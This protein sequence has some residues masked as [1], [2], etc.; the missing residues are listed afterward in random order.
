M[1]AQHGRSLIQVL[2][3]EAPFFGPFRSVFPVVGG[4]RPQKPNNAPSI[5]FSDHL[6]AFVEKCWDGDVG[7]RPDVK[8]VVT[9][10]RQT[11]TEWE[12]V[13]L[14]SLKDKQDVTT[15]SQ[16]EKSDLWRIR[17]SE[18]LIVP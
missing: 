8:E 9:C 4:L 7:L 6:W 10:L 15:R 16:D 3:G 12:G 18:P 2:T 14:H 17:E 5:G 11:N 1:R 13:M